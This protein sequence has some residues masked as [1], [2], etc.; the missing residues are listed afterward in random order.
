MVDKYANAL[1]LS[2]E[3]KFNDKTEHII[4]IGVETL[5]KH[6][7]PKGIDTFIWSWTDDDGKLYTKKFN[8]VLYFAYLPVHILSSTA[9]AKSMK[10]DELTWVLTER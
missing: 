5:G 9:L 2:E 10:D 4:S 1:I 3:Y 6:I 8:N 7:I